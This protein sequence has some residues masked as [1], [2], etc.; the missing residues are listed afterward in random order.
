M[1]SLENVRTTRS[2]KRF[3]FSLHS[4]EISSHYLASFTCGFLERRTVERLDFN[5]PNVVV[6][7][8]IFFLSIL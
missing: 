8:A 5:V 6:S 2:L 7:S 1:K 4:G 3:S